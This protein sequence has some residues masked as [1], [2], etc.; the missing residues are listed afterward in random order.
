MNNKPST[1]Y[2]GCCLL[3]PCLFLSIASKPPYNKHFTTALEVIVVLMC[4]ASLGEESEREADNRARVA[5]R[6]PAEASEAPDHETVEAPANNTDEHSN[7][8]AQESIT[9]RQ[10]L[11]QLMCSFIAL[12]DH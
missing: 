10:Q 3:A 11:R 12:E 4:L 5:R 8:E 6:I 7:P 9:A 2:F 1:F